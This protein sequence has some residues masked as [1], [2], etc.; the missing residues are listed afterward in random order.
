M[1]QRLA[2]FP[3]SCHRIC[4]QEFAPNAAVTGKANS[5]AQIIPSSSAYLA[6]AFCCPSLLSIEILLCHVADD[7][8]PP[9]VI[10]SSGRLPTATRRLLV[11]ISKPALELLNEDMLKPY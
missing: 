3:A 2:Q 1:T 9:Q 4:S 11:G 6:N 7:A 10:S 5:V 8:W